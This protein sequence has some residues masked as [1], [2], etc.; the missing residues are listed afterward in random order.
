MIRRRYHQPTN[1]YTTRRTAEGKSQR[2]VRRCLKRTGAWRWFAVA[3]VE[4]A[5]CRS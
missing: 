5:S 3:A 2:D 1:T 4:S